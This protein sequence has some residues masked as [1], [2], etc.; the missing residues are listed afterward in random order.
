MGVGVAHLG[1]LVD[2]LTQLSID[3]H[4]AL[5]AA[6]HVSHLCCMCVLVQLCRNLANSTP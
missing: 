6:L 4:D 3:M 2:T 1:S 5:Q